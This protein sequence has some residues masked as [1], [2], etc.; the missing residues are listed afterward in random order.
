MPY[1][2]LSVNKFTEMINEALEYPQALSEWENEFV[3][4]VADIEPEQISWK[5]KMVLYKIR[6]KVHRA[7]W[8]LL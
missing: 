4:S 8:R 1:E 6:D 3:N 7:P 5:Q 2:M